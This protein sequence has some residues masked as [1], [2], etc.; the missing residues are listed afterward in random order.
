MKQLAYIVFFLVMP[1]VIFAQ[2]IIALQKDAEHLEA[3]NQEEAFRRYQEIL[4]LQPANT[5]ALCKSS[6]LCSSIGHRQ[7]AKS[8]QISYFNA[9]RRF[10]GMA[11]RLEPASSEANLAMALAMGRLALVVGGREK[12]E[13]VSDVKLYTERSLKSDPNSF[14][15]WH[16]LGKWHY[17][18][19]NLSGFE[20]TAA[21]LLYGGLPPASVQECIAC[22]EK[23]RSL[24]PDFVLNYL[25]LAK[26]YHRTNQDAK[27]IEM[28]NKVLAMNNKIQQDDA[29]VK[30]EAR[31]LLKELNKK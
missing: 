28:L 12:I 1:A 24:N 25:E 15:A 10:A 9:A 29:R 30:E 26:A 16:V 23:S 2:D 31:K 22:Y 21:R 19:S 4:K 11:L 18:V 7:A 27:A 13:A 17:E 14:K 5:N 3:T 8:A 20:R 6:Q